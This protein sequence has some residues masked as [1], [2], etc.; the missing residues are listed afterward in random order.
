[1]LDESIDTLFSIMIYGFGL[2]LIAIL[3]AILAIIR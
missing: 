3:V 1:M 2:I